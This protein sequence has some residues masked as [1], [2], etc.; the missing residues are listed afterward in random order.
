MATVYGVNH[1]KYRDPKPANIV[2]GGVLGGNVKVMQDTYEAAAVALGST[3][4]MGKPLPKGARVL[5]IQLVT[6]NLGNNATLSVGDSDD[7]DR[8]YAATDHGAGAEK[9]AWCQVIGGIN[10]KILGTGVTDNL[11]DDTQ[12]LITT[13]V[14]AITGTIQMNVFYSHE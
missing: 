9:A 5:A 1:T 14:A 2:D 8:Y 11:T 4:K 7:I 10:Y 3:I 6:D 12:I 13:G